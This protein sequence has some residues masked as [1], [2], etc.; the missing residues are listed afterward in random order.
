MAAKA[1]SNTPL[2]SDPNLQGY[3]KL[4]DL[5]DSGPNGYNASPVNTPTYEAGKFNNAI[6]LVG[7]SL[8]Y[9][10]IED[11]SCPKLE[12]AGSQTWGCWVKPASFPANQAD[13]MSKCNAAASG[14]VVFVTNAVQTVGFYL[15]GLSP[16]GGTSTST[17]TTGVWSFVVGRYNA[18]TNTIDIFVDN[19]KTTVSSTVTGAHND[20]NARFMIGSQADFLANTAPFDGDID[21]A[22]V[23]DRALTDAEIDGLYNGTLSSPIGSLLTM[24]R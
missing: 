7:A 11:A 9:G 5:T 1:L 2:I 3:W 14:Y 15:L 23:F 19:V 4:E 12:I 16:Y 21:D 20:T 24:F 6:K 22:W 13:F 17:L 10:V 8:Q 18:S